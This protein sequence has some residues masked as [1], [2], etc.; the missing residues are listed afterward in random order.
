VGRGHPRRRRLRDRRARAGGCPACT[1][2][3]GRQNR[4]CASVGR[5]SPGSSSRRNSV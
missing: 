5:P 2:L 1:N 3:S 4:L